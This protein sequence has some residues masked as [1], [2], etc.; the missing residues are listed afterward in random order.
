MHRPL[1]PTT[2][3]IVFT[4]YPQIKNKREINNTRLWRLMV[5]PLWCE[6]SMK[7]YSP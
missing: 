5:R 6:I 7:T 1:T 3:P 2:Y 4:L